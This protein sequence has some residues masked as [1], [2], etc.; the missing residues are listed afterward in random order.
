MTDM[1][2]SGKAGGS[3]KGGCQEHVEERRAQAAGKC[4]QGGWRV[5]V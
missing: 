1:V 3:G 5:E 4:K 2:H